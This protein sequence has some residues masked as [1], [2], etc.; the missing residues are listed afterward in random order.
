MADFPNTARVVVIGGGVN[1]VSA[2]YHLARKGW[3]D[4]VLLERTELTAGSTW[5]AAG[6]LPLFNMSYSVG[7]L[8]QYSVELYKRLE[9]ETGQA[10]SF[11]QTGNL[12]LAT[13]RDRMDEYRN[14]QCTAET[15]GVECHLIGVEE[16][17][18]L[19]PLINA[20]GLVGA[21]WHPTDGH[22][23]P[24]DVTMALAKGARDKGG[25]IFQHTA[26]TGIERNGSA[27]WVVKTTKGDIACE[28][29]VCATGNYAR[30]TAK[31][32]GLEIPAVPVEHQYIV[33]DVDPVLKEYRAAGNP[34][35]PVLR[36]SDAQYYFREERNGWIL[37]PYEKHAPACF[38]DGVPPTFEKDLFPG[39]L[40]RLMP[41]VEACMNRVPSFENAGI[42][43]IVNGPISYTPDGNPMVGPAFGLPNLWISEGHSFG[44][45]AAGGAGWQ[46]A[47]WMVEGEPTV[48]MMG[49]DPRRFGVVSK[50][51]AK[52]KNEEAY[53]HVFF[54]HYPM[55]ERRAGRP[56]KTPP[57]YERLD[58]AGAVW[59]QAFG[60]ERPNWFAPQGVEAK[61]IYSFRRSNW[62]EHVGNEVRAMRER[63]GLLE[64]SSFAKYTVEGRGA[65]DWL[66][67]MIANNVP[68]SVGRMN[69][70]HAL[71]PSGSVRAEFTILRL[72]DGLYGERF[73]V[74]GPG[75]AHDMDW[76]FL[77]RQLPRDGSVILQDVTTQYGVF[78][79]AGPDSRKV[80][81]QLADA[82]VSNQG[83]PWLTGRDIPVGWCPAVRALRVNFV[84]SLGWEL[85][86][87]IEYQNHLY[88]QIMEAGKEFG[89]GLVGMRAM[90]SMRLEKSYRL[91]GTDLNAENS[92]LEAGLARFVRLN[93]AG[94]TGRE[95]LVRQQ[96]AGIPNTYCTIEIEAD[97]ADP[98]GNEPIFMDGEVVGRGT[99]GGYGHT[100]GKS[101]MLGYVKTPFAE[102]GRECQVRVLDQLRPARIVAESPY[103][104]DN[105]ALRA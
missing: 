27:E 7:Q 62:F 49:V 95:A 43:D 92:I 32:V 63:V 76:D 74:V 64:L 66:D 81:E 2:L 73:Y 45:T 30:T 9:A 14:Y 101:L 86:H 8:H 67:R 11:H 13:N 55:E 33:T 44:I 12:R 35:L 36:E 53:E 87:P 71:N 98:F 40:E 88:D 47:E 10:V 23:A 4:V 90:D 16:I 54:N 26:V 58:R 42:K 50:K 93:K 70:C 65:R 48:D 57:A 41:H 99:A 68:K 80:L 21:L 82:D 25:R 46:L 37:G 75:R 56:A 20:E 5:H 15:I 28:H 100:I 24:V 59:G 94:F 104:P 85:H 96:E 102:I 31:M 1:G 60:W 39:D 72:P 61:D 69:L 105:A 97:D 38:V 51:F 103:D 52:I 22:I 79:L 83:F 6:L 34:E 91:F 17:K 29:V 89:I 78:V 19:W 3:S 84:G 18:K 77:T